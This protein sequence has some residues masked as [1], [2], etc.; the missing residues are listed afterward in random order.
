MNKALLAL[1]ASTAFFVASSTEAATVTFYTDRPTFEAAL[2]SSSVIDFEGLAPDS[3]YVYYNVAMTDVDFYGGVQPIVAGA[4][5][6]NANGPYDSA[7]FSVYSA[8]S[9]ISADMT[10]AGSGFTAVGGR[11]GDMFADRQTTLTLMGS[12][13]ILD[14]QT[15]TA[16]DMGAGNAETFYGWT[17]Q[18]DEITGVSH[19]SDGVETLDD[20]IYG[21]AIPE[22]ASLSL[23]GLVT[24]GIYF[25]RRFF[26]A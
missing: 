26:V 15:V 8:A 9:S 22:P 12:N 1:I 25:I 3:S 20:L 4:N 13:G 10:T 23:I 11:F 24:G 7:I 14:T 21:Y 18:G 6:G 16:G 2:S 19:V 17:V 5:A